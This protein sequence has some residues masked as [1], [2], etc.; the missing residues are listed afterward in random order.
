[1]KRVMMA[2]ILA[3]L[4]AGAAIFFFPDTI[5]RVWI[6]LTTQ[7]TSAPPATKPVPDPETNDS[8]K[9]SLAHWREQLAR[10]YAS[11]TTDNERRAVIEDAR[12]ILETT[13]PV[14]MRTWLGTPWDFHGTAPEPGNGKVACGY[15][16]STVLRDAGFRVHR[17]H[18][19][20]QPSENIMR[21]FLPRS[22]CKLS[23]GANYADFADS[24]ESSE[25]GIYIVGLDTHVGF[26]VVNHGE[27][28]FIHS[29]G[30]RPWAVVDESR[31]DAHVLRNSNWRML[32][33]LTSDRELLIK[34]LTGVNFPVHGR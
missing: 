4:L 23:A 21:T 19:A 11:A 6:S 3:G 13:L 24:L 32:G 20:Q 15:F 17:Y 29:S 26:V 33:N 10:R 12:I 30:A 9:E 7:P 18:L 28:R 5:E 14:M 1:M 8:L 31:T 16:V 27:F 25:P 22:S 34:W 2:L